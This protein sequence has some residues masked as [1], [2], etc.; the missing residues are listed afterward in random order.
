MKPTP[1]SPPDR[2]PVPAFGPHPDGIEFGCGGVIA[3][4]TRAGRAVYFVVCL[5]GESA[6]H[7]G[8]EQRIVEA[9]H[10]AALR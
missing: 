8:P 3:Q 9:Q 5:R 2:L 7:G 4:E 10:A 6:T 1:S